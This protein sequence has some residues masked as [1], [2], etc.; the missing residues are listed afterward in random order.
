ARGIDT[1]VADAGNSGISGLIIPD[2]PPEEAGELQRAAVKHNISLTFLVA[3]TS[4]KKRITIVDRASSDFVYAVT[5]AGVTGARSGFGRETDKY[6]EMLGRRLEKPFVAGFG[7]ANAD[8]AVRLARKSA[9]V[10]I[11]SA[12][13]DIMRNNDSRSGIKLVGSLLKR[14]RKE[15][16]KSFSAEVCVGNKK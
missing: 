12:L 5:V 3:P 6:L 10:V 8:D 11:G 1:Y 2:L 9:G 7:I 13:V 15:L 16:D 14:I 4:S